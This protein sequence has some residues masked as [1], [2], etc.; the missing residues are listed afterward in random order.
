MRVDWLK[1]IDW[2]VDRNAWGQGGEKSGTG[3]DDDDDDDDVDDDDDDDD[4]DD[5]VHWFSLCYA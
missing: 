5:I 1:G 3:D 4:D 2:W